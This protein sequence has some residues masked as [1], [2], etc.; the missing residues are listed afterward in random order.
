MGK[1]PVFGSKKK[2]GND[3]PLAS[4]MFAKQQAASDLS[5]VAAAYNDL[6]RKGKKLGLYPESH[7]EPVCLPEKDSHDITTTTPTTQAV[8]AQKSYKQRRL[9][10]EGV[11]TSAFKKSWKLNRPWLERRTVE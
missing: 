5:R 6:L 3:I 7:A 4:S 9:H 1:D 11:N 8:S 2:A 10:G